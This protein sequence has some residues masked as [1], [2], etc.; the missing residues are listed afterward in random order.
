MGDKWTKMV[1]DASFGAYCDVGKPALAEMMYN[2][3]EG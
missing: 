3:I 1:S 2:S